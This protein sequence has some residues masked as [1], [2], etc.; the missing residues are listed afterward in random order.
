MKGLLLPILLNC[1]QA[2]SSA[3]CLDMPA[4][5]TVEGV[6]ASRYVGCW[7]AGVSDKGICLPHTVL[8][9]THIGCLPGIVRG[10]IIL[11][12]SVKLQGQPCKRTSG[13]AVGSVERS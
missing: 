11:W 7:Q 6:C 3:P 13:M 4:S 1:K 5:V 2:A 12:K 10:W 9:C 8:A